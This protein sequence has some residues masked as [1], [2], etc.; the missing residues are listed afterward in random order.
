MMP[1]RV[2]AAAYIAYIPAAAE[3]DTSP[4]LGVR[5]HSIACTVTHTA[6]AQRQHPHTCHLSDSSC[7]HPRLI[8]QREYSG[9]YLR[10][11]KHPVYTRIT[12]CNPAPEH[13]HLPAFSQCSMPAL[14]HEPSAQSYCLVSHTLQATHLPPK[15][16]RHRFWPQRVLI[17]HRPRCQNQRLRHQHPRCSLRHSDC[18]H[19]SMMLKR[20][21]AAECLRR[22]KH[23]ICPRNRCATI[24]APPAHRYSIA[25]TVI[26]PQYQ[27]P[28]CSL[29]HS[30]CLYPSR[31]FSAKLL[32]V[33]S[34]VLNTPPVP[35]TGAQPFLA[36][37]VYRYSIAR[38][39]NRSQR[40]TRSCL[41]DGV[42]QHPS[43]MAQRKAAV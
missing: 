43:T 41:S 14:E 23:P 3:T 32:L 25:H 42:C 31:C 36:E 27:H 20:K 6:P 21:A 35:I 9:Q 33:A 1:Q 12:R 11:F 5:R 16:V 15:Q 8:P 30:G 2:A 39:V 13:Q 26:R 7:Q 19:P 10:C 37:R 34:D 28:H 24:S 4:F 38:A 29:R 18:L 22:C 17:Q 40:H